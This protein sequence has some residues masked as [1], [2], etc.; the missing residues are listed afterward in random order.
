MS[1]APLS[2]LMWL[3]VRL[4][5]LVQDFQRMALTLIGVKARVHVDS[6]NFVAWK[7][8]A[9]NSAKKPEIVA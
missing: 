7:S 1:G 6:A 2:R 4:T 3:I 5:Q 8:L 9:R